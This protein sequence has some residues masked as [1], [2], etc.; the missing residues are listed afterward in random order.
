M[1]IGGSRPGHCPGKML[2]SCHYAYHYIVLRDDGTE[3]SDIRTTDQSKARRLWER[4]GFFSTH[5]LTAH[6]GCVACLG[7]LAALKLPLGVGHTIDMHIM[8][9]YPVPRLYSELDTKPFWLH[10]EESGEQPCS[11]VSC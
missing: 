11:E 4:T 9:C 5:K 6:A 8:P 3:P 10:K 7:N 1:G 2:V